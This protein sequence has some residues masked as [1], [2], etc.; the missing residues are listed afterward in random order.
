MSLTKRV[1]V[2]FREIFN[3]YNA[4][5]YTKRAEFL[6]VFQHLPDPPVHTLTLS[7]PCTLGT[8]GT[9]APGAYLVEDLPAAQILA[10][11]PRGSV[12]LSAP[13]MVSGP[14]C[15]AEGEDRGSPP[16]SILVARSGGFG[17]LLFLGPILAEV[18]RRWP[19]CRI[20]V[21]CRPERRPVLD[22]LG[23]VDAWEPVPLPVERPRAYQR[24]ISFEGVVEGDT[25]RHYVDAL[26]AAA[27]LD[28]P[29]G[30]ESRRCRYVVAEHERRWV[31]EMYPRNPSRK[32]LGVQWLASTPAR[33]YPL[34]DLHTVCGHLGAHGW[35]VWLLGEPDA[36]RA[37]CGHGSGVRNIAA[38][39]RPTFRQSCAIL[40]TCDVVLAPDSALLH[41][42][43]A[44]GLP[45]VGLFGPIDPKLRIAYS[46]TIRPLK[47]A[48][49]C[50]GCNHHP[51]FPGD[52]PAG[53]PCAQDGH[54]TAL[55]AIA[56]RIVISAVEAAY[57]VT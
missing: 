53:M 36:V 2:C 37:R 43:G 38:D 4:A 7:A 57:P 50:S 3:D 21:A 42:A 51:R 1:L 52:W 54:C 28:L 16:E 15:G 6:T 45:A 17:D 10:S 40:S 39:E 32:R 56:P 11:A 26:A 29:P 20:G 48:L 24:L 13:A 35:D 33:S 49:P 19:A 18:R 14:I 27:G 23:L 25:R 55:A 12:A 30:P 46:P 5:N 22:G 44:L 41:V 31:D 8:A 9:I 34:R 47:G